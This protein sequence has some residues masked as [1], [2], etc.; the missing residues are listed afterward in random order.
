MR[1]DGAEQRHRLLDQTGGFDDRVAH[2]PHLRRERAHV[3]QDDGL[4][5]RLHL[6]D[7]IVHRGDQVLDVDAIERRDEGAAH[8]DQHV[9]GGIV[10]IA[11]ALHH[12]RAML[13]D[14]CAAFE[15]GT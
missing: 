2:L 4:G 12:D 5:G 11:F 13:L 3:E 7:G 9:A 1:G 15:H 8:R 6:I 14:R 10:G